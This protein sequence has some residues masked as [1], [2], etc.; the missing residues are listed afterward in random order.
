MKNLFRL[1]CLVFVGLPVA[2]ALPAWAQSAG[3]G[4]GQ[5]TNATDECDRSTIDYADEEGLTLEEKIRRMD[6]ALTRPL[7]RYDECAAPDDDK[8]DP[9][10]PETPAESAETESGGADGAENAAA[11]GESAETAEGQ[12]SSASPG[13]ISGNEP[14]PDPSQNPS[15][16]TLPSL[17]PPPSGSEGT[18]GTQAGS[19]Q[20][21]GV[22]GEGEDMPSVSG[23][24]SV[25]AGDIAGDEPD[26]EPVE[27]TR[28]SGAGR[29]I[30]PEQAGQGG[31][32]GDG[33]VAGTR[34]RVLNNGKLPED[35]PPSDNDSVLEAQ[36]RQA[37]IDEPD[38]ELKKKLW[39]EYRRYKGLPQVK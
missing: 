33:T 25:A 38:P 10:D 14:D 22:E 17:T 36:I 31:G 26:P 9:Q 35:I 16:T 39:N 3:V 15:V 5:I 13:D 34:T 29:E 1:G 12:S 7:N 32:T 23:S 20:A 19:A 11:E 6:L 30:D 27:Q 24:P 28:A 37:A 8:L 2:L 4:S 21:T 18:N